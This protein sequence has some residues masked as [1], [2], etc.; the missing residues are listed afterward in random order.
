[1]IIR[2][3]T[4]ADAT[5]LQRLQT[6]CPMGT[7]LVVR[8]VN[9]PD[10]F[11]RA[12]S[13]QDPQVFVALD[14]DE[15]AGTWARAEKDVAIGGRQL[16]IGY[17]FQG[18]VSPRHR[19]N[20]LA[21]R[22]ASHVDEQHAR[23]GV[24]IA[25]CYI[26]GDNVPS[27]RLMGGLGY[28]ARRKIQVPYLS[29]Y[30]EMEIPVAAGARVRPFARRDADAVAELMNRSWAR[31][32]WYEPTTGPRLLATLDKVTGGAVE[33][34]LVL[35]EDGAIAAWLAWFDWQRITEITVI[36]VNLKMRLLG[37]ALNL[38]RPLVRVPRAVKAGDRLRQWC[39]PFFAAQRPAQVNALLRQLNNQ[40]L[41]AGVEQI[42]VACDLRAELAAITRGFIAVNVDEQVCIKVFD[43]ARLDVSAP[44]WVNGL[45]L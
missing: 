37:M 2:E 27:L 26:L 29:I 19:R 28:L 24:S 38:V 4:A 33:D 16:R 43:D 8:T 11:A 14:G 39:V 42:C 36:S 21:Q 9:A 20:R 6:D 40:A 45:D 23:R 35:E 44:A 32:D 18:F 12:N 15:I 3:A 22:L 41:G 25:Y 5:G 17:T 7:K 13:Y 34:A 1:M 30:R 31:H 10:F